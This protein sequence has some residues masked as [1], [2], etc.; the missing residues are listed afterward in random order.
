MAW[1]FA[2]HE[3]HWLCCFSGGSKDV[4]KVYEDIAVF[5][6]ATGASSVMIA[7]A[8]EWNPSIFR[9]AGKLPLMEVVKEYVKVVILGFSHCSI[10]LSSF[11]CPLLIYTESYHEF[12]NFIDVHWC[13]FLCSLCNCIIYSIHDLK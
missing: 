12:F 1:T 6:K 11:F 10:P 7:R 2:Q 5:K 4:I 13:S 9:V 3:L 8:A